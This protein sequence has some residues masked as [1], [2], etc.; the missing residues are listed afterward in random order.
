MKK[1][2]VFSAFIGL[3]IP[4]SSNSQN[5]EEGGGGSCAQSLGNTLLAC[6]SGNDVTGQ[7][8][9]GG[10]TLYFAPDAGIPYG[11]V[12]S[13][14]VQYNNARSSCPGAPLVVIGGAKKKSAGI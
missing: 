12:N 10:S 2:I 8:Y 11:Q 4:V 3:L 14:V 13:C 7:W 9:G 5:S 1:L 6:F